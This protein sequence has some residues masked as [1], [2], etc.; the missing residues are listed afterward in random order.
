MLIH[1]SEIA[2]KH[3]HCTQ[4]PQLRL[5]NHP[6]AGSKLGNGFALSI[7]YVK[8][9]ASIGVLSIWK[10]VRKLGFVIMGPRY[11]VDDGDC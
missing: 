11:A 9:T 8:V 7:A 5:Q 1:R 3:C 4:F 6:N 10:P 2:I